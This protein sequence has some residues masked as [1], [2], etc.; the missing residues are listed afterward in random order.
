MVKRLEWWCQCL[1]SQQAT[2]VKWWQDRASLVWLWDASRPSFTDQVYNCQQHHHPASDCHPW[3]GHMDW[4]RA[5]SAQP[6]LTCSSDMLLLTTSPA[7]S[8]SSA[9]LWRL[10]QTGFRPRLVTPWLLQCRLC[11]SSTVDTCTT[12]ESPAHSR[13]TCSWHEAAWPCNFRPPRV[14]LVTHCAANRVQSTNCS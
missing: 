7:I 8:T 12:T 10:P 14:A 2:A 9:R 4:F 11:G 6:C 5:V 3:C 1:V 13:E